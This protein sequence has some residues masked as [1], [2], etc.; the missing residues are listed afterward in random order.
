MMESMIE[1]KGITFKTLENEIFRC[2]CRMGAEWTRQILEEMDRRLKEARDR[3]RYR[4]K[5]FRTTTI[6]TIYGEVTYRRTVYMGNGG[7]FTCWMRTC[8]STTSAW[9]PKTVSN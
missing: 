1:E 6:K 9:S 8:S 2:V 5:G 4:D 7:S 3:S